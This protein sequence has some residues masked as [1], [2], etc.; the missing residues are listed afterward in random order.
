MDVGANVGLTCIPH[1]LL[2]DF[3]IVVAA[4]PEGRNFACLQYNVASNGLV[5]RVICCQTAVG[6]A[7]GSADLELSTRS[8]GLHQVGRGDLSPGVETESVA[9]ITLDELVD[10]KVPSEVAVNLVKCDT[11]G[12]EGGVVQGAHRLLA[13]RR[14]FWHMEFWPAGMERYGTD[15]DD[16]C[17]VIEEYFEHFVDTRLPEIEIRPATS[18]RSHVEDVR[19]R[20]FTDVLL[21]P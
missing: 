12:F 21:M 5:D 3:D 11:Q 8:S 4:E 9:M 16:F 15:V 1:A 20:K 7:S 19:A 18:L 6:S 17:T 14:A 10:A 2:D 13:R